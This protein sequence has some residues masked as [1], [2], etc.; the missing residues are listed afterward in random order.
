MDV[1]RMVLPVRGG[2][3]G[4]GPRL[5]VQHAPVSHPSPLIACPAWDSNPGSLPS[6]PTAKGIFIIDSLH[7][8]R[9][10][11]NRDYRSLRVF[12]FSKL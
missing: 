11:N 12:S 9:Y 2:R 4:D 6:L 1:D 10:S 7:Q 8:E 3:R 5:M